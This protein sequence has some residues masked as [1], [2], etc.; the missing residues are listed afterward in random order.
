M[1]EPD[2]LEIGVQ[3]NARTGLEPDPGVIGLLNVQTAL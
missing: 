2:L 3:R 1:V